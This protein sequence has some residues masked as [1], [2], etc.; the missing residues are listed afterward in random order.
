MIRASTAAGSQHAFTAVTPG[1]GLNFQRRST[2]NGVSDNTVGGAG[3]AP[4]WV[5]LQRVGNTFTSSASTN[6]ATWTT[7][8][9]VT[10]SMGTSVQV[11][12]A[13]TSHADGTIAT[14]TFTDVQIGMQ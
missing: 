13:V 6:G 14:A 2:T 9:S 8:G 11:G 3:A 7:I 10:I 5:R 4:Y 1:N 12:L